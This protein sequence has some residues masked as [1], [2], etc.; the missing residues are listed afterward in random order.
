MANEAIIAGNQDKTVKII[1]VPPKAKANILDNPL[2][3]ETIKP[4]MD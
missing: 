1:V 4:T 2:K 3:V